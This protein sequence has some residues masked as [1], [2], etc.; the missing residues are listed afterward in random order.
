MKVNGY[1][2]PNIGQYGGV[3]MLISG[4]R[5]M[6][7]ILTT[8]PTSAQPNQVIFTNGVSSYE[9]EIHA[10]MVTSTQIACYTP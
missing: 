9:C 5:F 3:L 10:E 8:S 7:N 6:P 2:N 1:G 4:V